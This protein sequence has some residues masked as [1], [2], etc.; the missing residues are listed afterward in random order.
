M[1]PTYLL[2]PAG[3]YSVLLYMRAMKK[4]C[5]MKFR[6]EKRWKNTNILSNQAVVKS[7]VV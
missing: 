6:V 5:T 4:K 2:F 7:G 1:R 3:Q